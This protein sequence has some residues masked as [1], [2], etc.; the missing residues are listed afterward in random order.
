MEI[1]LPA[2][3]GLTH[4]LVHDKD[5]LWHIEF[6]KKSTGTY[7]LISFK[8]QHGIGNNVSALDPEGGP[9]LNVGSTINGYTVKSIT[10]NGIFELIKE[11]EDESS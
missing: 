9:F 1:L 6:D 2:R 7:R 8:G 10:I 3:Y 5:D 4:K 11:K